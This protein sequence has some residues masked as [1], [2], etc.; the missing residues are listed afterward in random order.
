MSRTG[1][2]GNDSGLLTPADI[3][4]RCC[5]YMLRRTP[6]GSRACVD[7]NSCLHKRPFQS[8]VSEQHDQP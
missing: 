4:G 2:A 8:G 5:G 3:Y 6:S 1:F 7:H